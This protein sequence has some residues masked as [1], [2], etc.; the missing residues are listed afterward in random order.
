MYSSQRKNHGKTNKIPLKEPTNDHVITKLSTDL[1][2]NT[3]IQI[4]YGDPC[5]L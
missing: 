3:C 5:S 1:I 4:V 2:G